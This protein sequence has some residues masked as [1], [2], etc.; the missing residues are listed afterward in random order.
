MAPSAY[1]DL[2]YMEPVI[3]QAHD[4]TAN[5]TSYTKRKGE[6][7]RKKTSKSAGKMLLNT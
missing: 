6:Q 5:L 2:V 3:I 7:I 4:H 1:T